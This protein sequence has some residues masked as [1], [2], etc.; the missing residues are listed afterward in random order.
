M[1]QLRK[2]LQKLRQQ[3]CMRKRRRVQDT[4]LSPYTLQTALLISLLLGY[5]FSAGAAWLLLRRRRGTQ[6]SAEVDGPQAQA[7]LEDAFL[8]I[9]ARVLAAWTDPADVSLSGSIRKTAAKYAR[10]YRLATWVQQRNTVGAVVPS[11]TLLEKYTSSSDPALD[12]MAPLPGISPTTS[13]GRV[14]AYRWR[15]TFGAR[16]MKMR[17]QDPTPLEEIRMKVRRNA[18]K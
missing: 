18:F 9:D 16:H 6:L 3:Q 8:G 1:E 5:D 17:I 4:N 14:W 2:E 11:C 12:D 10:E 15:K 13:H 7:L